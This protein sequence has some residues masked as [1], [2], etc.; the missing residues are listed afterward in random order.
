LDAQNAKLE[1]FAKQL[2]EIV[3]GETPAD[4][5]MN[6]KSIWDLFVAFW[7]WS[8]WALQSPNSRQEGGGLPRINPSDCNGITAYIS[9]R[10]WIIGSSLGGLRKL[11]RAGAKEVWV[12]DLG[13]DLRGAHGCVR[14]RIGGPCDSPLPT[15]LWHNSEETCDARLGV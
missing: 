7:V 9:N 13:G 12:F 10:T 6:L 8:L 1:L 11:V 5:R 4:A 15:A 14:Q 2:F 3:K